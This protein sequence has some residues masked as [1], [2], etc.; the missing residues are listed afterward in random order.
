M[1]DATREEKHTVAKRELKFRR[2][3][4]P[5]FVAE[6]RMTQENADREIRIME[7]IVEDYR[8]PQVAHG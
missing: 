2:K 1:A 7:A 6:G 3:A 4:Y 5:R 8:P